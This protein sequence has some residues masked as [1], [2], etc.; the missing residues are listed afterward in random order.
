MFSTYAPSPLYGGPARLFWLRKVLERSGFVVHNIVANSS[1]EST[2]LG[3]GDIRVR[4]VLR[5]GERHHPLFE[6]VQ[7]GHRAA[8][9]PRIVRAVRSQLAAID[10]DIIWLEQP[11]L[12][13]L[14][15]AVGR[16]AKAKLVYSSQNMERE[17]KIILCGFYG[18]GKSSDKALVDEV[19]RVEREAASTADL[20]FS[21]CGADQAAMRRLFGVESVLLPNGSGL[22][23]LVADQRSKY[24]ELFSGKHRYF[25]F[26]GS[27]YLPNQEGLAV[28]AT[29]SLAFLPPDVRI[30]IAGSLGPALDHHRRFLR[31]WSVNIH[32]I[33][34]LGF[35]DDPDYAQFCLHLPCTIVP[36]FHGGGS[37]LKTADAL[38]TGSPVI[39]SRESMVGYEDILDIDP[40]NLTVVDTPGEFRAAMTENLQARP[41]SPIVTE[42]S[43]ALSWSSRLAPVAAALDDL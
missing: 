40:R 38:V 31:Q 4:P 25:G 32:R 7:V 13:P 33:N 29:P 24:R 30:A 21:I 16:S 42:R 41:V 37:N 26:A 17:L 28:L 1:I 6:D 23:G 14:V 34:R 39:A 20:V 12:L 36:I 27:S 9:Q 19:G 10:P 22:S 2:K 43:R 15:H 3:P 8:A 11:W 35:L 5:P 18:G